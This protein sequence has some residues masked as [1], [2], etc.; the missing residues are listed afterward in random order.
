M[1]DTFLSDIASVKVKTID[2]SETTT[3]QT[4]TFQ[5]TTP[6]EKTKEIKLAE[7]D[8]NEEIR[9]IE[10]KEKM[11]EARRQEL[12]NRVSVKALRFTRPRFSYRRFQ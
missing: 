6:V 11:L 3:V 8:I 5:T 12:M 2:V 10:A 7:S 1:P 4:T 9:E